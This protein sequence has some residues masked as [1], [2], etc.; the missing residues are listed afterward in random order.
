MNLKR[1]SFTPHPLVRNPH[2]QTFLASILRKLPLN[3]DDHSREV[4]LDVPAD[5]G[6]RLQGFY[7][8]QNQHRGLVLL[9]HGWLGSAQS[10]YNRA[11][12][13]DLFQR[14]YSIFRLN[15][16]DHGGTEA[17]N[18]APFHG[19]RL[20][21][22][23]QAA[24]KIAALEPETPFF[25]VGFSMGGNF[26]LR[27]AYRAVET[28]IPTLTHIIGVSPS[29]NPKATVQAIDGAF[30]LYSF[31]FGRKWRKMI[32]AKQAAFPHLYPDFDEVLAIKDSY[33]MGEWFIPRYSGFPDSDSYYRS[34]AITPAM[35]DAVTVPT[36]VIT[37]ADD[38]IVPVGDFE[39]FRTLENPNFSLWI[40]PFGG[41]VGFV[42]IFPV[43]RWITS[44]IEEIVRR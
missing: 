8:P 11:I 21:E 22:A 42:D 5:G 18:P 12:G 30:P 6:T 4:L 10:T 3:I 29:V 36:T 40:Q 7:T 43:R 25:I 24:E 2:V 26:A 1:N 37:A 27:M 13:G 15:M 31:Y 28:P 39:P 33:E 14:G 23:F 17:L 41:H 20:E 9:L 35:M 19:A 32:H 34:Y 16:R 38:P 44:A